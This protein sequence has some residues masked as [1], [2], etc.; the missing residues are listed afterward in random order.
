VLL[1]C[2]VETAAPPPVRTSFFVDGSVWFGLEQIAAQYPPPPFGLVD[3][4]EHGTPDLS[5]GGTCPVCE[6]ALRFTS[7]AAQPQFQSG[8]HGHVQH[9]LLKGAQAKEITK[10][11]KRRL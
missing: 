8:F 11:K 10:E 3:I 4:R 9:P 1:R 7:L 6:R 2:A 5:H